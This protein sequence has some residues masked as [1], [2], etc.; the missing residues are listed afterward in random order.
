MAMESLSKLVLR[1]DIS[2][3]PL[4][5]IDFQEA[6]KLYH[7]N[8]VPYSLG[9]HLYT[10]HGGINAHS[11]LRSIVEV[12]SI[13]ATLNHHHKAKKCKDYIPPLNN[14]ALFK[15]DNYIC[16]YCGDSFSRSSLSRDHIIPVSVGGEDTWTNVAT[17]CKR[18][19]NYKAG[20]T[21]E[22]AHMQLIAIPFAPN[23]AEY[24]F[25]QGR[26]ILSDQM[27]FLCSHFP[28]KSPLRQRF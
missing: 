13:I 3:M 4:G 17:A 25:L 7:L 2:G 27:E 24:V 28:H 6:V 26:K 16:L 21:P 9:S 10:I 20:R 22:Q 12:N 23:R 18:C 14:H 5:W 19:N 15:R 1:T 11:G 8:Q